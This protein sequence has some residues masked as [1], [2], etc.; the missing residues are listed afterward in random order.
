MGDIIHT[1]KARIVRQQGPHRL[2]YLEHF[3]EPFHYGVHGGIA[4]FY[5]VQPEHEYPATLDHMIAAV[6][7]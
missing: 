7:G 5:R 3:P 6:A 2:A 4:H 1:S